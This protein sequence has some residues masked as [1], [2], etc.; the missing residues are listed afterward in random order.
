M[1]QHT[2]AAETEELR[3][4]SEV[5]LSLSLRQMCNNRHLLQRLKGFERGDPVSF[6]QTDVQQQTPAAE[7]EGVRERSEVI[8]SLSLR[9]MCNNTHL[10]QRLKGFEC[11]LP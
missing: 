11:V 2:P 7:T 9:Q 8:L 1:Q 10:L 6:P 5:I 4:R 3:E